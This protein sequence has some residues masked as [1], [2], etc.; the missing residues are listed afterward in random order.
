ME[1]LDRPIFAA[2]ALL[3]GLAVA[4]G[5]FGAHALKGRLSPEALGW[6]QTGVQYQMAHG[7]ALLAVA[8][9]GIGRLPAALLGGGA[10]AFSGTLYAMALGAPHWLGA[11]TPLGGLAMIA[12]WALAAWRASR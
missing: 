2:G 7:L 4:L 9:A 3:S 1:R 6:W 8:L 11:V 10:I 12:G 5:A